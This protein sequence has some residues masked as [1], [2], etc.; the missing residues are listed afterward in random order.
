MM[1]PDCDLCKVA[2]TKISSVD[3]G[4]AKYVTFMCPQCRTEKT[5]CIG[6]NK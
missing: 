5:I 6:V 2:M 3:S 4:N 1:N